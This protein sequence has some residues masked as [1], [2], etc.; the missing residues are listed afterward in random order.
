MAMSIKIHWIY[1]EYIWSIYCKMA[2]E[3]LKENFSSK[4]DDGHRLLQQ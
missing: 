1:I 2:L 4:I 3:M